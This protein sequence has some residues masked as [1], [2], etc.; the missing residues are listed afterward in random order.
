MGCLEAGFWTYCTSEYD[1]K[2]WRAKVASNTPYIKSGLSTGAR[3][4]EGVSGAVVMVAGGGAATGCLLAATA[5]PA[6]GQ[7]ELV[8]MEL[9]C[10]AIGSGALLAGGAAVFNAIFG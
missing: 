10:M 5:T 1:N 6:D 2:S 3:V 8:P 4:V 7:I 9:H